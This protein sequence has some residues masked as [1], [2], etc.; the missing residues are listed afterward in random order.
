MAEYL[1]GKVS[2]F[3]WE[4]AICSKT[5]A[6]DFCILTYIA[7]QQ[8]HDLQEKDSWLSEKLW[9]LREFSPTEVLPYT[10]R[11]MYCVS[12][13]NADVCMQFTTMLWLFI[14]LCTSCWMDR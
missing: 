13:R 14:H 8:G 1:K 3:E 10:V 5:V 6:V 11:I 4:V 7:S 9:K 2:C 12:G